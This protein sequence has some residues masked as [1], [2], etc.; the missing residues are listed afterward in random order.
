MLNMPKKL[1]Q[2]DIMEIPIEFVND[3]LTNPLNSLRDFACIPTDA[4]SPFFADIRALDACLNYENPFNQESREFSDDFV[5]RDTYNRYLHIDLATKKDGIGFSM[6]HVPNFVSVK[7]HIMNKITNIDEE[8][9]IRQ[10]YVKFDFTGRIVVRD[11]EKGG[12]PL[13]RV[14]DL[15][16]E[17]AFSRGF[18]INLITFDRVE[19]T[20]IIQTLRDKGLNVGYMSI[21]RTAYKVVI[22]Y[23]KEFNIDRVSTDKQYNAAFE[24][25]RYAVAEKRIS[26]PWY[27]GWE[28]ETRG[29]EY[30]SDKDKVVKSPH[31]SDDGIQSVAG[32]AFNA[33]N[34]E[35][36]GES[37]EQLE[38][39]EKSTQDHKYDN[40]DYNVQYSYDNEQ[41][42]NEKFENYSVGII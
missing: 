41:D 24:T 34:N 4:I 36:E 7:R 3:F 10:P 26:I 22:D 14:V 33:V 11:D 39:R 8:I 1:V 31:S 32:S 9:E 27:K 42:I 29:L 5:C 21:D 17:L 37:L 12:I 2:K 25:L 13:N 15:V 18:N 6:C 38:A 16:L 35:F 30:V 20:L 40:K 28:N 23:D 19:S